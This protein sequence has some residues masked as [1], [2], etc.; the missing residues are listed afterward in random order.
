MW[1]PIFSATLLQALFR[2]PMF[3]APN[4]EPGPAADYARRAGC[5]LGPKGEWITE[6]GLSAEE[7]LH[8][9]ANHSARDGRP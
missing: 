7:P 6:D 3:G 8:T 4:A 9:R 5:R 2:N 1:I